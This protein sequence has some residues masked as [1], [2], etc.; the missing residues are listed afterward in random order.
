MANFPN[1][2]KSWK[3][4]D[5]LKSSIRTLRKHGVWTIF[6]EWM[7]GNADYLNTS[8]IQETSIINFQTLTLALFFTSAAT[9]EPE[10]LSIL[11]EAALKHIFPTV[12]PQVD[13]LWVFKTS[14]VDLIKV[15]L[16]PLTGCV[17]W[18]KQAASEALADKK[19][20]GAASQEA[21]AATTDATPVRIARPGAKAAVPKGKAKG[22]AKAVPKKTGNTSK[23]HINGV[24]GIETVVTLPNGEVRDKTW[25]EDL[26]G[27]VNHALPSYEQAFPEETNEEARTKAIE[28]VK[29]IIYG[30][31]LHF[32]WLGSVTLGKAKV[33]ASV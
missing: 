23:G 27:V 26:V 4:F 15:I 24:V 11:F 17:A 19:A 29:K 30:A 10:D 2:F 3:Q 1:S 12:S 31:G 28:E 5:T 6:E 9:I 32:A 22:K 18:K 13:E 16:T 20:D 8:Y 14:S 21:P 25:L 33:S 7:G